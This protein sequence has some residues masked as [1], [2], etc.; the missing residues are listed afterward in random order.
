M[1]DTYEVQCIKQFISAAFY[2]FVLRLS[3]I[4]C[5]CVLLENKNSRPHALLAV[6]N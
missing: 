5:M 1:F 2:T 4:V 3:L 6:L